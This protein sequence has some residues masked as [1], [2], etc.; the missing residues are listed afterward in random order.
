MATVG[1]AGTPAYMSPEQA[2][3]EGHFVDGRADIFS[4]GVVFYE[5]LTPLVHSWAGIDTRS[6]NASARWTPD[7]HGN[8]TIRFPTSWRGFA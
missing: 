6:S 2:R 1:G 4:L 8:W 5:L 7:R 3:G